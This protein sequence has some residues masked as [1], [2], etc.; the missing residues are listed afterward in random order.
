MDGVAGPIRRASPADA[1]SIVAVLADAFDADP[2][3][4]WMFGPDD[5]TDRRGLRA[6]LDLIVGLALPRGHGFVAGD[7]EG[8]VVWL[9]PGSSSPG[10]TVSRRRADCSTS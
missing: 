5:A 6:W 7:D 10:P 1:G 9:P 8:A 3:F 2:C 4:S